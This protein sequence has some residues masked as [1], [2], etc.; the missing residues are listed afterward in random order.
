MWIQGCMYNGKTGQNRTAAP[1]Q[2]Y[3]TTAPLYLLIR[4]GQ[5]PGI[6]VC[7]G[8]SDRV[9]PNAKTNDTVNWDF[10]PFANGG[11]EHVSY[12]YQCPIF[13]QSTSRCGPA[14][15]PWRGTAWGS[16]ARMPGTPTSRRG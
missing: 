8:T 12:S 5:V 16:P 2:T 14:A 7:P 6:F 15:T 11:A 1:P 4:N 3:N 13:S 9:D 10:S